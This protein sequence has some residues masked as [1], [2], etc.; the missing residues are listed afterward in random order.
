MRR[1]MEIH[2]D[3]RVGHC[4]IAFGP[5]GMIGST[6]FGPETSTENIFTFFIITSL[7]DYMR[8]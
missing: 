1:G 8:M 4:I 6:F 5:N 3:K 7:I 2:V